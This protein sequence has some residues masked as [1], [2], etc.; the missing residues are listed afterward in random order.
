MAPTDPS[1]TIRA[2][3]ADQIVA[4]V[5]AFADILIDCVNRGASVG[6]LAPL[7]PDKAAKFWQDIASS[8]GRAERMVLAAEDRNGILV[9]TISIVLAQPENQPHRADIAK[10][11]VHRAARRQGV[12]AALLASAE[13]AARAESKT[14][15][16]LDTAGAEAA[17][18]Y[19]KAGWQMVGTIPDYALW[20]DGQLCATTIFYKTL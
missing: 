9:G 17:A 20:P 12:G 19:S 15:L 5:D 14:V 2:L 4:R 3:T 1:F 11:L 6:F 7:D 10:M 8:V 18:L 13:A 16:V